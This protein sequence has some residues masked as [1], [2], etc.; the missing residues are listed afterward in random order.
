MSTL[1]RAACETALKFEVHS[2]TDM[3]GFGLLNHA[4]AMAAASQVS[5]V[6]DH[7]Q[8]EFLPGA[9]D[10]SRQG[11]LPGGL[12]R[13]SEF[14]GGCVEFADSITEEVRNLLFDPQTSG[15]LLLSVNAKDSAE[16]LASLQSSGVIA[17]DVGSVVAKTSPLLR[18]E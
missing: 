5:L 13:N 18:V 12:K 14:L 11:F 3:T 4:R 9:L 7:R 17:Q 15:G 8:I 2:A 16:L 6:F 10:Y 1:N